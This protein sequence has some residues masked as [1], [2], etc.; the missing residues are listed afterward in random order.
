[1]FSVCLL[2]IYV[3]FD[4]KT[5]EHLMK[6]Y[7]L[8]S[9]L[10]L[11]CSHQAPL[12]KNTFIKNTKRN[13]AALEYES[14]DVWITKEKLVVKASELPT[15]A[16]L[17]IDKTPWADT[18]WP[19]MNSGKNWRW[20]APAGQQKIDEYNYDH[21]TLA[22][23]RK[24]SKEKISQLSPLE[25]FSIYIGDY[26]HFLP[27]AYIAD[28]VPGQ[29]P[30]WAGVCEEWSVAAL[31]YREPQA[32]EIT[33]K[34]GV[35]LPFA[36][37]DIKALLAEYVGTGEAV[38]LTGSQGMEADDFWDYA[39]KM[40][41]LTQYFGED[42]DPEVPK[43]CNDID[44]RTFHLLVTNFIGLK[45]TGFVLDMWTKDKID[46]RSYFQPVFAYSSRRINSSSTSIEYEMVVTTAAD[47][48]DTDS[49]FTD[50]ATKPQHTPRNVHLASGKNITTSKTFRYKLD[51][52]TRGE[53]MSGQW[54]GDDVPDVIFFRKKPTPFQ[55]YMKA[56]AELYRPVPF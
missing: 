26:E 18:N 38:A 21:P 19:G 10:F 27:G 49:E 33:N 45:N 24:M 7:F 31:N 47:I 13:V 34:D 43:T 35:V 50:T 40:R 14:I 48:V 1:M 20:S 52:N 55:G 32:I 53:I 12:K 39:E 8:V 5:E 41:S 9:L 4:I 2:R 56:L 28:Y 46:K 11:A 42:C 30:F 15:R 25:K 44:P 22:D 16:T 6:K 51:I 23:L 36:S 17:S 54:I 29:D 3:I 37:S